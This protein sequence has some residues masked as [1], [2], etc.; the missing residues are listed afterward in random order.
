MNCF[1]ALPQNTIAKEYIK[2]LN[3]ASREELLAMKVMYLG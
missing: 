1:P 3:T 2:F